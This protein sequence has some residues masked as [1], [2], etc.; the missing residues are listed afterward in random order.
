MR[1]LLNPI[2]GLSDLAAI[3]SV[4]PALGCVCW[5]IP[6]KN[7]TYSCN[8]LALFLTIFISILFPC[9]VA[10]QDGKPVIVNVDNFVRAECPVRSGLEAFRWGQ[11]V[12]PL[13]PADAAGPAECDPH[14]PGH[15]LQLGDRRHQHRT[16]W[17]TP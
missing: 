6:L 3:W 7:S 10:A 4:I 16:K 14:E 13:S 2:R 8:P 9:V 1:K 12:A 11:Q 15:A 17:R 5:R